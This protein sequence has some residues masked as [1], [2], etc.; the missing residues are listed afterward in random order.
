MNRFLLWCVACVWSVVA[1]A[2]SPATQPQA[3]PA[4]VHKHLKVARHAVAQ[5]AVSP[6]QEADKHTAQSK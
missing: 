6:P 4:I 3:R 1:I 5:S 2:G